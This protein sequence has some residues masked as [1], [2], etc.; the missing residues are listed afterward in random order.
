MA[1][2][3]VFKTTKKLS[4]G[5]TMYRKWA[6]WETGDLI[7]CKFLAQ[8]EDQYEKPNWKVQ[9]EDAQFAS[10]KESKKYT[11]Q[12]LTL[13][14]AGQ[15]DKAMEKVEEGDMIQV[16]YQGTSVIEK[17]KFKGKDA[18]L[19]EVDMVVEDTGEDE[20][21]YEEEEEEIEEDDL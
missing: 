12:V 13:N 18:H 9:V 4:G 20:E 11:G 10:S 17:G 1:T 14:S 3:R 15:L 16:T 8:G 7:I 19:V 5:R 21:E 2:K 6:E